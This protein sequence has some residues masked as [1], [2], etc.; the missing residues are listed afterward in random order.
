MFYIS[1]EA[2]RLKLSIDGSIDSLRQLEPSKF[3]GCCPLT[4]CSIFGG[5]KIFWYLGVKNFII[6]AHSKELIELSKMSY[7]SLKSIEDKSN[8]S[9]KSSLTKRWAIALGNDLVIARVWELGLRRSILHSISL[10][11]TRRMVYRSK[12]GKNW[13]QCVD[14]ALRAS[15]V[16]RHLG[17]IFPFLT[18]YLKRSV[19]TRGIE[20]SIDLLNPSS[21]TRDKAEKPIF[22]NWFAHNSATVDF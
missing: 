21:Q 2:A 13:P 15:I 12:N 18:W 20:C 5:Q 7:R 11:K 3:F 8:T 17:S 16:G 19:L 4:L 10:V 1:L 22:K 9:S 6:I 14:E